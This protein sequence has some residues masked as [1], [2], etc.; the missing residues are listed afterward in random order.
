MPPVKQ[1]AKSITAVAVANENGH[2]VV[3]LGTSNGEVIKIFMQDTAK[4]YTTVQVW[5]NEPVTGDL[6]FGAKEERLYVMSTN[7]V[8]YIHVQTCGDFRNCQSCVTSGDPYCGWC[9]AKRKCSRK[10][11]CERAEEEGHWLW[12]P[13]NSCVTT[14]TAEPELTTVSQG[15]VCKA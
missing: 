9:V 4:E 14:V 3:F 15:Y 5:N 7:K 1:Y 10:S 2:I 6:I 11:V 8:T 13:N 12:S